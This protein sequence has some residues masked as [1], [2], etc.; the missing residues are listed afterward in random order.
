M[1][2]QPLVLPRQ[3]VVGEPCGAP[4]AV[5]LIPGKRG[6]DQAEGSGVVWDGMGWAWGEVPPGGWCVPQPLLPRPTC[7]SPLGLLVPG[8]SQSPGVGWFQGVS[9]SCGVIQAPGVSGSLGVSGSRGSAGPGRGAGG[10][11]G[12]PLSAA[13]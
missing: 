1:G 13:P 6:S 10:A 3:Q 11:G 9:Q 4:G 7:P 2:S 5:L 12:A 8:V